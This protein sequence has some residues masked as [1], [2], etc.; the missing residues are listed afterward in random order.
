[1]SSLIWVWWLLCVSF[2]ELILKVS[3]TPSVLLGFVFGPA[4]CSPSYEIGPG[5]SH[6]LLLGLLGF[7]LSSSSA[8]STAELYAS[9][10][11][12]MKQSNLCDGNVKLL[13]NGGRSCVG[14]A[15]PYCLL[16]FPSN[17]ILTAGLLALGSFPHYASTPCFYWLVRIH[18][19]IVDCHLTSV[20]VILLG[21]SVIVF[22]LLAIL[23]ISFVG[24]F[25]TCHLDLRCFGFFYGKLLRRIMH[26]VDI[27]YSLFCICCV[28]C[29]CLLCPS[30]WH[31]LCIS[32]SWLL[33]W[34]VILLHR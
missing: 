24:S 16:I 13:F 15:P 18:L 28:F 12:L 5:H 23:Y 21:C 27:L 17:L 8:P 22:M 33:V 1:M 7:E 25:E 6:R 4:I 26:Y 2:Y 14:L 9:R 31:F 10:Y 29:F 32:W 34:L 3:D 11:T 20:A 30:E 19:F